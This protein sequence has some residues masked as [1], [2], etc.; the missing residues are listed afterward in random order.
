MQPAGN[1]P[2]P[3]DER[4][5]LEEAVARGLLTSELALVLVSKREL[6][7]DGEVQPISQVILL[8]RALTVPDFLALKRAIAAGDSVRAPA[9]PAAFGPYRVVREIS[10]GPATGVYEAQDVSGRPVAIKALLALAD[11]R[12]PKRIRLETEVRALSRLSHEGI[13]RVHGASNEG[14][15]PYFVMDLVPGTP[16]DR[17]TLPRPVDPRGAALLVANVADAIEH[18]HERGVLHRDLKPENVIY[19]DGKAVLVGFG[20]AKVLGFEARATRPGEVVGTPAYLAPEQAR[21]SLGEVGPA[22]D[23]Y[24]LGAVLFE[25]LAG[26]P[27]FEGKTLGEVLTRVLDEPPVRLRSLRADVPEALEQVISK[28]LEKMPEARPRRAAE[29]ASSLRIAVR[30]SSAA[31]PV[32]ASRRLA[33]PALPAPPLARGGSARL[34]PGPVIVPASSEPPE[35]PGSTREDATPPPALP[36]G[37]LSELTRRKR[38][39]RRVLLALAVVLAAEFPLL[40]GLLGV[41]VR[42]ARLESRAERLEEEMKP[43]F[44]SWASYG[45]ALD[46]ASALLARGKTTEAQAKLAWATTARPG[47]AEAFAAL[48]R[49]RARAGPLGLAC[50]DAKAA[51]SRLEG[52]RDTS[53]VRRAALLARALATIDEDRGSAPADLEAALKLDEPGEALALRSRLHARAGEVPAAEQDLALA[54]AAS[55][56]AAPLAIARALVLALKGEKDRAL[57]VLAVARDA[58]PADPDLAAALGALLLRAGRARLALAELETLARR[59][60]EHGSNV[61]LL[62]QAQAAS[63]LWDEAART[64]ARAKDLGRRDPA[65]ERQLDAVRGT[66]PAEGAEEVA[67]RAGYLVDSRPDDARRLVDAELQRSPA[68][69]ALQRVLLRILDATKDPQALSLARKLKDSQGPVSFLVS[70]SHAFYSGGQDEACEAIADRGIAE[71]AAPPALILLRGK[72]RL[73]Q[74]MAAWGTA[75]RFADAASDLA[76]AGSEAGAD[77]AELEHLRA[78]ALLPLSR[79]EEGA[80]ALESARTLGCPH[81]DAIKKLAEAFKF[82]SPPT[83]PRLDDVE[84]ISVEAVELGDDEPWEETSPGDLVL[85]AFGQGHLFGRAGVLVAGRA[86]VSAG[87]PARRKGTKRLLDLSRSSSI[88]VFLAA[89]GEESFLEVELALQDDA[90]TTL[91]VRSLRSGIT[92][93]GEWRGLRVPLVAERIPHGELWKLTSEPGEKALD[94]ARV[95]RVEVSLIGRTDR[96]FVA[97]IDGL[98]GE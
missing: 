88:V 50:E 12:A 5:L 46:A 70:L 71:G 15:L 16:L 53:G 3:P 29:L 54:E 57:A 38:E 62:A 63:E 41:E 95:V 47:S 40:A 75:G 77:R 17:H 91:R 42:R 66:V 7:E 82:A 44:L 79:L 10:R 30:G 14:G 25:L 36:L 8:E 4:R 48:A 28:A 27:P 67:A 59:T 97:W 18:A 64:L 92:V 84:K 9:R 45:E 65:L 35:K 68:S 33:A 22:A 20:L 1:A 26:S 86:R 76:L 39:L 94:A 52:K 32:P 85:P 13:V 21:P 19:A 69:P 93:S 43:A 73:R 37:S 6:F 81:A 55:A 74:A 87:F 78:L 61:L 31:T 34:A 56:P 72:A 96:P 24:G 2:L 49:I 90:G 89:R 11:A 60:P 80:K 23:V 58:D 98:H 51:L 83:P